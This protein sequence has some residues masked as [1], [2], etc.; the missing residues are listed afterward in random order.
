M[1]S[2]DK[3]ILKEAG[4]DLD[5]ALG[6]FVNNEMLFMTFL[7]KVPSDPHFEP[8]AAMI[9]N[10]DYDGAHQNA[11]AIKGV[12]G[13]LGIVPLFDASAKLCTLLKEA[14]NKEEITAAYQ[15]FADEFKK[16]SDI[17]AK[18]S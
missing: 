15:L 16:A 8:I 10:A 11:H 18:M 13:N 17:I 1:T 4:Y 12:V 6:R 3:V 2:E 5:V 7:K 9:E 14:D